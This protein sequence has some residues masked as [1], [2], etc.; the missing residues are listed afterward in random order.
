M[1]LVHLLS[2]ANGISTRL[3]Q[4]D[5]RRPKV[6]SLRISFV[7]STIFIIFLILKQALRTHERNYQFFLAKFNRVFIVVP[8]LT[9][10]VTF[11]ECPVTKY[12][13]ECLSVCTARNNLKT[14]FRIRRY[15]KMNAVFLP[16]FC[17][18]L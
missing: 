7:V 14:K 17:L 9:E 1:F 12:L 4:V 16:G 10:Y 6:N 3:G 8:R 11:D 2:P 13:F 5:W 18:W 15:I